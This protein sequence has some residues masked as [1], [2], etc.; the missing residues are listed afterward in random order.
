MNPLYE[1]EQRKKRERNLVRQVRRD[2]SV[3]DV[4]PMFTAKEVE[5]IVN[6]LKLAGIELPLGKGR[7][8]KAGG[9]I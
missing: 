3:R 4:W 5:Q 8:M 6:Q 2:D 9:G 7:V 1:M